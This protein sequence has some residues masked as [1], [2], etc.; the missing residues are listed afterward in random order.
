MAC[1]RVSTEVSTCQLNYFS[2]R[3]VETKL[4]QRNKS[5]TAFQPV[6]GLS[7]KDSEIN[8]ISLLAS[9]IKTERG[10]KLYNIKPKDLAKAQAYW[11]R[12]TAQ[13]K[14]VGNCGRCGQPNPDQTHKHCPTCREYG[15]RYKAGK[16]GRTTLV[17]NGY[18]SKLEHRIASLE[19]SLA[20]M[21][22][23]SRLIYKRGYEKGR[24]TGIDQ[25]RYGDAYK[26]LS[27]QEAR[28]ISHVYER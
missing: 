26:S 20:L 13:R 7:M 3:A 9:P 19:H 27:R 24:T 4:K 23:N 18:L 5:A 21:Q 12:K 15:Q 16:E 22:V 2:L 11:S 17:N 14:Q 28:T 1:T 8:G 6:C 10:G 25:Y